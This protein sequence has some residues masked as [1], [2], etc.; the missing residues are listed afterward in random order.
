M[1][2]GIQIGANNIPLAIKFGRLTF[3]QA[4][5]YASIVSILL[6][7]YRESVAHLFSS[8][9]SVA[10]NLS[11]ELAV[12]IFPLFSITIFIDTALG[13]FQG[14]VRALGIQAN[15]VWIS[16][17][18]FYLVSVPIACYLAFVA[19]KGLIGLWIGHFTGVTF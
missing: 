19:N 13:F 5:L 2:I 3:I 9:D 18:S 11:V 14:C 10:G 16:M 7:V 17:A 8:D 15:V 6:F 1:L 12:S 4:M